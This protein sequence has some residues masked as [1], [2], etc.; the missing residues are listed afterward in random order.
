MCP[1]PVPAPVDAAAYPTCTLCLFREVIRWVTTVTV[2]GAPRHQVLWR[3]RTAAVSICS[4]PWRCLDLLDVRMSASPFRSMCL[5]V[6]SV[7]F[8]LS[9]PTGCKRTQHSSALPVLCCAV[10]CS[11]VLYHATRQAN[12]RRCNTML[13][14]SKP[15]RSTRQHGTI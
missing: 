3:S 7:L 1:C 12:M 6:L 13:L 10:P 8:Q 4:G 11:R 9:Q 2:P 14:S 15:E 5:I